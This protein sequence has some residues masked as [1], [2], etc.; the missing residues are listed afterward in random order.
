MPNWINRYQL[1][2]WN[3]VTATLSRPAAT[4]GDLLHSRIGR[5]FAVT[6][7][8]NVD[9]Q[10]P[11]PA[12]RQ[13]NSGDQWVLGAHIRNL[14]FA[15]A[16]AGYLYSPLAETNCS[17]FSPTRRMSDLQQKG[18]EAGFPSP[19]KLLL[20]EKAFYPKSFF[21]RFS[22]VC[23]EPRTAGCISEATSTVLGKPPPPPSSPATPI[24]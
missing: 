8:G 18:A 6:S 20:L 11:R 19:P 4:Y 17:V 1:E 9:A 23:S 3:R 22:I 12:F 7:V 14:Q 24:R 13:R 10:T 16:M 5:W 21:S 2:Y 15:Y